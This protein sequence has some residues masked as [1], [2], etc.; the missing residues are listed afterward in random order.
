MLWGQ[1]LKFD[2]C[3][4]PSKWAQLLGT[5]VVAC[6]SIDFSGFRTVCFKSFT[7]AAF[8][9]ILFS[10]FYHLGTSCFIGLFFLNPIITGFPDGFSIFNQITVQN[11]AINLAHPPSPQPHCRRFH[12]S[13]H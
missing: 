7:G 1:H 12:F 4:K 13:R 3:Q 9:G 8:P 6:R 2:Q 10:S 11:S 5:G